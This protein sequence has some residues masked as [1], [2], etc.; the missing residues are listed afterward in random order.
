MFRGDINWVR[1]GDLN[2]K[3]S[4]DAT[5]QN[6]AI[7]TRIR[8]PDYKPPVQYHDIALVKLDRP[9][10]FSDYVKPICLYTSKE[11]TGAVPV[12][13]GWGRTQYGGQ[14]SDLLKKVELD[15]Y[16]IEDCRTTYA[17]VSQKR[18]PK[19]IVDETQICAGGVNE[20]KDT[21]QV[22]IL[23]FTN[24]LKFM[25]VIFI[26]FRATQVDRCKSNIT[27]IQACII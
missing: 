26:F 4:N 8:H 9:A 7:T 23:F 22:H 20:E 19:G 2:I 21:C 27:N 24:T 15:L 6:F 14:S 16:S 11:L 5:V 17:S 18:L 1:L 12:A 10:V 13:T 25:A 3:N